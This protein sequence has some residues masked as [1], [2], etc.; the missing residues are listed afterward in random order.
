M[1]KYSGPAHY[2]RRAAGGG[3]V[4]GC[5]PGNGGGDPDQCACS[6][7]DQTGTQS[8]CAAQYWKRDQPARRYHGGSV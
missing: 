7:R 2:H 3:S 6:G 5:G 1:K 8:A 4:R